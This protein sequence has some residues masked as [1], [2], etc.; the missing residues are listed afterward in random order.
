MLGFF[1]LLRLLGINA[2]PVDPLHP[3]IIELS[4]KESAPPQAPDREAEAAAGR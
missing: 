4:T 2:E 1:F 3:G